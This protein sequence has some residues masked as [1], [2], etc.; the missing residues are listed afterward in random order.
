MIN[1]DRYLYSCSQYPPPNTPWS[2]YKTLIQPKKISYSSSQLIP[3]PIVSIATTTTGNF[4]S[5]FYYHRLVLTVLE[6]HIMKSYN[7]YSSV[8]GLIQSTKY[9]YII[10][11][12][13]YWESTLF[14]CWTII[15]CV[16]TLQ[17]IYTHTCFCV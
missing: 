13:M 16:N 1:F 17:F 14:Y 6:L 8:S 9:C 5:Y 4:S 7:P 3:T 12:Y 2:I 15:N 10:C 11:F